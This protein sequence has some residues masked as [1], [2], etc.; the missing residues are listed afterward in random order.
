MK[1]CCRLWIEAGL[2]YDAKPFRPHI[3]LG[4]VRRRF[5]NRRELKGL[6]LIPSETPVPLLEQKAVLQHIHLYRTE[7]T[8]QGNLY[9]RLAT[10]TL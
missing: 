10:W 6:P 8:P 3:T 4:R 9:R 1:P 2:A 5:Q 7:A